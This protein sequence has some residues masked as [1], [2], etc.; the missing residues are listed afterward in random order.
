MSQESTKE[1][2]SDLCR[3]MRAVTENSAIKPNGM[4]DG[5]GLLKRSC[6]YRSNVGLY[7][8]GS[9]EPDSVLKSNEVSISIS[10]S[11]M[12][13]SYPREYGKD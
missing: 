11:L 13:T 3:R 7:V 6:W 10:M 1:P 8:S 4:P 9:R 5:R 12:A 2:K